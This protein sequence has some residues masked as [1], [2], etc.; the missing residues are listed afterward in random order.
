MAMMAS[1]GRDDASVAREVRSVVEAPR[2]S[3]ALDAPPEEDCWTWDAVYMLAR[4]RSQA[5][6]G[7]VYEG[8]EQAQVKVGRIG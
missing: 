3:P 7:L 1:K 4:D 8:R 6:G 5:L 2:R